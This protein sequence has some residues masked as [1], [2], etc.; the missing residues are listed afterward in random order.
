MSGRPDPLAAYL[1]HSLVQTGLS[2]AECSA[3]RRE[4]RDQQVDGD[5]E[6]VAPLQAGAGMSFD[7]DLVD[8]RDAV[9]KV[10]RVALRTEPK[11]AV[12]VVNRKQ[13]A[14]QVGGGTL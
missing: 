8:R 1:P 10:E 7:S 11:R 6:S 5:R 3:S 9:E 2:A 13:R 14:G 4:S 12:L